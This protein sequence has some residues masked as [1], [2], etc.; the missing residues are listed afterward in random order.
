MPEDIYVYLS[1]PDVPRVLLRLALRADGLNLTGHSID[2]RFGVWRQ[3][4]PPSSLHKALGAKRLWPRSTDEVTGGGSSSGSGR[5]IGPS[6]AGSAL[7]AAIAPYVGGDDKSSGA[8][9]WG[10]LVALLA[11]T[12]LIATAACLCV[13]AVRKRGVMGAL[14]HLVPVFRR[15]PGHTRLRSTELAL[16]RRARRVGPLD[17]SRFDVFSRLGYGMQL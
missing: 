9:V 11:A 8:K 16:G 10:R 17:F 12:V 1:G 13:G 14:Q 5:A 3:A 2:P 15:R 7:T 6:A 4:T